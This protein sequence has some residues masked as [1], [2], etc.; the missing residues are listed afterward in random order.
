MPVEENRRRGKHARV[1]DRGHGRLDE[2]RRRLA[3]TRAARTMSDPITVA[4]RGPEAAAR[5]PADA[6]VPHVVRG[7]RGGLGEALDSPS[8]SSSPITRTWGGSAC[9][10]GAPVAPEMFTK[11]DDAARLGGAT[12]FLGRDAFQSTSSE[13]GRRSIRAR[14]ARRPPRSTGSRSPRAARPSSACASRPTRKR[15]ASPSAPSSTVRSR[16]GSSRRTPST[17][18]AFRLACW[19]RSAESRGRPTRA[20]SGPSSSFTSP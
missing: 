19:K 4:N 9:T 3:S 18:R 20:F 1:R 2:P 17:R 12:R 8:P 5:P 13:A 10:P 14:P 16:S 15:R 7:G 6:L 11:T